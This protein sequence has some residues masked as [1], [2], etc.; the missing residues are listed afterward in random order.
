MLRKPHPLVAA[1]V[2]AELSDIRQM[3]HGLFSYCLSII[4][5]ATSEGV[6]FTVVCLIVC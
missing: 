1:T 3:N 5:P 6:L 4:T 2:T